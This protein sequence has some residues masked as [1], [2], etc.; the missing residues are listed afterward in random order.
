MAAIKKLINREDN[1]VGPTGFESE[2]INVIYVIQPEGTTRDEFV[3][4]YRRVFSALNRYAK[5]T[6]KATNVIMDED[7]RFAIVT[8]KMI[9]ED[10]FFQWDG[11]EEIS[12]KI[13]IESQT[14]SISASNNAF[15][16][17]VG[18]YK[19]NLSLLWDAELETEFGLPTGKDL[20]KYQQLTPTDEEVEKLF[21]YLQKIWNALREVLPE[22]EKD[23][24]EMRNNTESNENHAIF[25]PVVQTE[26]FVRLARM[27]M[28]KK[29]ITQSSSEEDMKDALTP[30]KYVPWSL[31]H[32]LWKDLLVITDGEP[33]ESGIVKY[34]MRSEQRK[35]AVD[36]GLNVLIWLTKLVDMNE[37]EI[38]EMQTEWRLLLLPQPEN[39]KA[40]E[41][42][43]RLE[44]IRN[45]I[46]N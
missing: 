10:E 17:L 18:F 4:A 31:W 26:I 28:N 24:R 22:I 2:T 20:T 34:K 6:S 30:L 1:I 36:A 35:A 40:T 14:E 21:S 33:T 16:T 44:E 45:K 25:R 3:K 13:D 12:S 37:A 23:P 5:G 29:R 7:D 32:D 41:V 9:L 15:T 42:F 11:D 19:M 46:P 8:R 39:Q 38:Q 43:L 27:L